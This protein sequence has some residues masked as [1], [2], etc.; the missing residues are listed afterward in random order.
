MNGHGTNN[1]IFSLL[2]SFLFKVLFTDQYAQVFRSLPLY[3][4]TCETCERVIFLFKLRRR[5]KKIIK[6]QQHQQ[7]PQRINKKIIKTNSK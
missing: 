7:Q 1:N 2:C 3:N 6:L 5:R 4:S